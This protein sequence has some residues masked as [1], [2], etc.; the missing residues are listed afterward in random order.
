[1]EANLFKI[2]DN[3]EK[4]NERIN[5]L[6][7]ENKEIKDLLKDVMR[8]YDIKSVNFILNVVGKNRSRI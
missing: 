5:I 7:K 3:L 8:L 1:M 2:L 4:L 6:E